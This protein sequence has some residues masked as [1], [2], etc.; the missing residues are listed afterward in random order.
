MITELKKLTLEELKLGMQVYKEQLSDIYDTWIILYK[1]VNQEIEKDG[2]I[3]FIGKKTNSESFKLY[4]PDNLII[5]VYNDSMEL[6]GDIY[7]EE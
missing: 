4:T 5:P 3:G 1:P 7:Y 6:E 2:I